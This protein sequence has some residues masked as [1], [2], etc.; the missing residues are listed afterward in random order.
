M[1]QD[2][3][4][5]FKKQKLNILSRVDLSLKG[6]I[7]EP[8]KPLVDTINSSPY[9]CTTSTCSGRVTLIEKSVDNSNV[10]QNLKFHLRA[11]DLV[12]HDHIN[13]LVRD[14]IDSHSDGQCL[15]LKFEPFIV[16]ILCCDL[17]NSKSIIRLALDS[18]CRNSGIT[19]TK[20]EGTYMAAIRSTSAMEVP[21]CWSDGFKPDE[22]YIKF[23]CEESN[24]R[25]ST[26]F[27]RLE[28]FHTMVR[29]EIITTSLKP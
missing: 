4:E 20:N 26:N 11:H 18:G 15:W 10:K 5:S 9:Y 29:R 23:L 25:L 13:R 21:I 27:E 16:H 22:S 19:F 17:T 14:F 28:K 3:L 12:D 7:D 6:S 24:Y 2:Y 1:D 8:I